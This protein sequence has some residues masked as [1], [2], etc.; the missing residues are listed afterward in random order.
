MSCKDTPIPEAAA[1]AGLTELVFCE[2]FEDD[3]AIDFSGEGKPGYSFYA[4][5]VH[6]QRRLF[7]TQAEM[8]GSV[9][10]LRPGETSRA[11]SLSSYSQAGNC[12][13]TIHFGYVEARV[14]ADR[15][16][17][18]H[19][20]WPKVWCTGLSEDNTLEDRFA[21]VAVVEL[22]DPLDKGRSRSRGKDMIYAG[23][24]H[25]FRMTS[26]GRE[27][28]SNAVNATGYNDN[29]DYVDT[30]WHTYGL[31]WEPGHVAWY[32]DNQKMHSV[33]FVG[34]ALPQYYYRDD[35]RPLPRIEETFPDRHF[36][37]WEG[38]HTITDRE[39]MRVLLGCGRYW[40]MD[41]DW[42]RVW[43]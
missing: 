40:T 13:F 8:R 27:H 15:P 17:G 37:V 20:N 41:V 34:G 32:M 28:C 26:K 1:E 18:R 30:D 12:G 24:L 38:A 21:E 3:F 39:T 5:R 42:V 16:L 6:R 7:P 14:R 11:V 35:P 43:Q 19:T 33:R 4:D 22:T 29:F 2:D 31:L 25:D 36:D 9:L 10:Y 23:V